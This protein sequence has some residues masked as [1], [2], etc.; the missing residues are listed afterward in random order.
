M[1]LTDNEQNFVSPD[2]RALY[3]RAPAAPPG[4]VT[5]A[6]VP[7]IVTGPV[8][9]VYVSDGVAYDN[10]RA[11]SRGAIVP[12]KFRTGLYRRTIGMDASGKNIAWMGYQ[13]LYA[14]EGLDTP[15]ANT[16]A[17]Q[18]AVRIPSPF[19]NAPAIPINQDGGVC[20]VFAGPRGGKSYWMER[21]AAPRIPVGERDAPL[22]MSPEALSWALSRAF[23]GPEPVILIDSPRYAALVGENLQRGGIPREVLVLMSQLEFAAKAF[24]KMVVLGLNVMSED[25]R[26]VVN[27]ANG[28]ASSVTG[29][30]V[31]ENLALTN[32]RVGTLSFAYQIAPFLRNTVRGS[33]RLT[34]ADRAG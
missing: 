23:L 26:A 17:R 7:T 2:E 14:R 15:Q 6:P 30:I 16:L 8:R 4:R 28:V 31:L 33:V 24:G 1:F 9:F 25:T 34:D 21:M 11:I 13:P 12:G 22:D 19:K 3:G 10:G 5:L 20:V 32:D 27:M 29:I 18:P